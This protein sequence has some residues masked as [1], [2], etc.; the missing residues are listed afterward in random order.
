MDIRNT[1]CSIISRKFAFKRSRRRENPALRRDQRGGCYCLYAVS[2]A[3]HCEGSIPAGPRKFLVRNP[4]Q[5][6]RTD[7]WRVQTVDSG[8]LLAVRRVNRTRNVSMALAICRATDSQERLYL[9]VGNGFPVT[10]SCKISA[11]IPP[12]DSLETRTNE[13]SVILDCRGRTDISHFN[14]IFGIVKASQTRDS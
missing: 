2:H 5:T 8:A 1:S 7:S 6:R 12:L 3:L 14:L 11:T 10:Q 9:V 13:A 4:A